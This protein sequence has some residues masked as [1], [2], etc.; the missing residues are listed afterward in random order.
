MAGTRRLGLG[1]A[2]S[3]GN[4][5]GGFTGGIGGWLHDNRFLH[6]VTSRPFTPAC[7]L[8]GQVRA[9]GAGMQGTKNKADGSFRIPAALKCATCKYQTWLA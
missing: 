6:T 7:L 9:G 8:R 1:V 2:T 5:S 3:R 4:S